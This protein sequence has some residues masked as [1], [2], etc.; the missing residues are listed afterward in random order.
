MSKVEFSL[1]QGGLNSSIPDARKRFISAYVTDTRLMGVLALYAHWTVE[2]GGDLHQFFYIDCEEA[3]L[4][5]CTVFRGDWNTEM[6]LAQ[7]ALVGGLGAEKIPLTARTFRWLMNHW[8]EFNLQ[9]DLPLPPNRES[10][11]FLFSKKP[12]LTHEEKAQLM[13]QICG[14]ITNDYQV[15]NY[16]LMRCL[17]RDEEGA[18][19]LAAEGVPL[20]SFSNYAKATFCKNELKNETLCDYVVRTDDVNAAACLGKNKLNIYHKKDVYQ[21]KGDNRFNSLK[22]VN[23]FFRYKNI[24]RGDENGKFLGL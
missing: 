3:G 16:F 4:E 23:F 7:Q 14:G 19:Y 15:V 20:D 12:Q 2:G 1:L 11:D 6:E 5:T 24:A 18:A 9:H 10:Y 17:G 21:F 22:Y 8:R 13:E